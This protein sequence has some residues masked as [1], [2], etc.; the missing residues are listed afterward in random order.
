MM[1]AIPKD[2]EKKMPTDYTDYT[3]FFLFFFVFFVC[4]V[5]HLI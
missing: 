3:D 1:Q 5:D 2:D 4:F